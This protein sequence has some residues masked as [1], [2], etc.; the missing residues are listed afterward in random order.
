MWMLHPRDSEH[1]LDVAEELH[2]YFPFDLT[3]YKKTSV[4]GWKFNQNN[5]IVV[6]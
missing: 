6:A 2:G 5:T 1:L 3:E 4:Q